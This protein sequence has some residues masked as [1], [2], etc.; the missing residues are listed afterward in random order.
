MPAHSV[1]GLLRPCVKIRSSNLNKV[2]SV[3]EVFN[4]VVK[5]FTNIGVFLYV[6]HNKKVV[7][8]DCMR[9]GSD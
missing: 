4:C 9:L 6:D 2:F 7:I 5:T 3:A 1:N 8:V